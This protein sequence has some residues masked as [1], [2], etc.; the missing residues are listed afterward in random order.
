MNSPASVFL[1]EGVFPALNLSCLLYQHAMCPDFSDRPSADPYNLD[2]FLQAQSSMFERVLQEL[3]A[4]MKTSHWIWFIF[5]QIRGL[6]R[7]P[8]SIE[9]AIASRQEASAYLQHPVLGPRLKEC[10]QLVLQ[11]EGRSVEQIFGSPDDL[12]FRS[13]MTLFAQ[14]SPDDDIFVRALQ[15]YFGGVPDQLTLDRL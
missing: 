6:G 12:K 15:K 13:S 4:G 10:T 14:V 11:V 5:P 3:R 1:V 2:R 8:I 9:F 7:S